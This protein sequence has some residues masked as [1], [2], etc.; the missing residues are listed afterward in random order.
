MRKIFAFALAAV[1]IISLYGT[2]SCQEPSLREVYNNKQKALK[3][4]NV[5][6]LAKYITKDQ[7]REIKKEKDPKAVVFLMDYH[8][9]L[10]YS[11]SNEQISG[12]NASADIQGKA[13]NP[14]LE[15]KTDTFKGKVTFRQE[16]GVWK[17]YSE[18]K[19]FSVNH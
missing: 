10:E 7:I 9:P 17:V 6:E 1:L 13:R 15:G 14:K 5:D 12:K 16:D 19:N 8:S 18:E 4:Q 11:I 2:G 3:A